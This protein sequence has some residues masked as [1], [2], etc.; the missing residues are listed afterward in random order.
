MGLF[1]MF[2]SNISHNHEKIPKLIKN[3]KTF[4]EKLIFS[5]K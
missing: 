4:E 2:L 3:F 1:D 5:K